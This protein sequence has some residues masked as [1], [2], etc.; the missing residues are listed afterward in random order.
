MVELAT[1]LGTKIQ[2]GHPTIKSALRP[3]NKVKLSILSKI[4]YLPGLAINLF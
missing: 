1:E 3:L 4:T 2:L